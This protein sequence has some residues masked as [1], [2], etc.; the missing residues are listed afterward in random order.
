VITSASSIIFASGTSNSFTITTSGSPTP[1]LSE[2]GS[3]PSGVTF[4][5]NHNGTATLAGT[6]L[7]GSANSFPLTLTATSANGTATQKFTLNVQDGVTQGNWQK[8]YGLL[9]YD[10]SQGG[11]NLP[12]GYAI[13]FSGASNYIWAAST[14]DARALQNP[15][16]GREA[17]TWYA[18]NSNSFS[19]TINTNDGLAHRVALYVVDWDNQA[20]SEQV[21]LLDPTGK[22]LASQTVS[23]FYGGKYLGFITPNNLNSVT[24]RFTT[25]SGPNAVL[26]GIFFGYPAAGP[27][28]VTGS[29]TTSPAVQAPAG[30]TGTVDAIGKTATA[31]S[32]QGA[33]EVDQFFASTEAA[34]QSWYS[35]L[36]PAL[37]GLTRTIAPSD[38]D[39]PD[40]DLLMAL[41]RSAKH[42]SSEPEDGVSSLS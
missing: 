10:L 6:P 9:G 38:Q 3:L 22:V 12:S 18:S 29:G 15:S 2:S 16:G 35:P 34:H 13:N 14:T 20:R 4:T 11:S 7:V 24:L 27:L 17:A 28:V 36:S 30:L 37:T 39:A 23:S 8:V 19:V 31:P 42:S 21:D 33:H 26:S 32:G 1:A 40:V 5:D 41:A 25:L